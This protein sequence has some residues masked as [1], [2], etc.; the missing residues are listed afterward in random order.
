MTEALFLRLASHAAILWRV[1]EL[2]GRGQQEALGTARDIARLIGV[3]HTR[4]ADLLA[5]LRETES[6]GAARED[7]HGV[8]HVTLAAVKSREWALM[9]KGARLFKNDD[10]CERDTRACRG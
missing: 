3:S 5:A 8:W 1:F 4:I 9:L 6:L 7:S 2:A 10:A